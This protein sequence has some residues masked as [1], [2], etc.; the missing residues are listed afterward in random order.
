MG[1]LADLLHS[2]LKHALVRVHHY[3]GSKDQYLFRDDP[4][5]REKNLHVV[6]RNSSKPG[7][8]AVRDL[9]RYEEYNRK[10]NHEDHAAKAWI[11]GFVREMGEDLATELLRGVGEVARI[12]LPDQEVDSDEDED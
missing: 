4:R 3:L 1:D 10:A 2:S 5:L 6:A 7:V 9:K 12:E 11:R 8:F